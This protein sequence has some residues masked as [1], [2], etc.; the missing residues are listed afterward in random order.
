[1]DWYLSHF[2]GAGNAKAVG[3]L[4]HDYYESAEAAT[5]IH[6]DIPGVRLLCCLREPLDRLRSGY[7]YNR[8]TGLPPTVSIEEYARRPEIQHQFDYYGHLKRYV[9][10]FGKD[11]VL[12]LFYDDLVRDPAEFVKEVYGFLGVDP[13]FRPPSLYKRINPARTARLEPLALLAY[14]T[15]QVF[16]KLGM[17]TLVG[18]VKQSPTL[19]RLLYE[20]SS[21]DKAALSVSIPAEVAASFRANYKRLESLLGRPLPER[22]YDYR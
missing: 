22:W 7:I 14:R 18:R 15:G 6:R 17:A 21:R 3:E 2:Q 1:M 10:L 5:R 20:P 12:V 11:R 4:S 16:R 19:N 9:D 8:T 13:A